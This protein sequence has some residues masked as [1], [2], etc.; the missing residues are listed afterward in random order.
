MQD[1]LR[2]FVE[3]KWDNPEYSLWLSVDHQPWQLLEQAGGAPPGNDSLEKPEQKDKP[4]WHRRG[5]VMSIY[6]PYPEQAT[7][8]LCMHLQLEP[9]EQ[10]LFRLSSLLYPYA[11]AAIVEK[12]NNQLNKMMDSIR[13]VTQSVDLD[14]L[15]NKILKNALSVIPYVSVGVLWMFDEQ[16][17]RLRVRARAGEMG[18]GML[19]MRLKPDEGMI[20][21]TFLRGKP[22]LYLSMDEVM[23]DF[24]NMSAENTR[25]LDESYD[26]VNMMSC[27]TVPI[28]IDGQ[29]ECVLI[30]YQNGSEPLLTEH[31]MRLLQSF[32]DQVSIAIRNARLI[33]DLRRQNEVLQRRD[34]IH[35][36][37]IK[38]SLDNKGALPIVSELGRMMS[39]PITYVDLLDAQWHPKRKR[40]ALGFNEQ[41]LRQ[42]YTDVKGPV[43][44]TLPG[45]EPM[46]LYL[47]PIVAV[48]TC[49]GYL[50]AELG[51]EPLSNLQQ[52]AIEQ[53]GAVLALELLRKQSV[54]DIY[55]KQTQDL[56]NELLLAKEPE[57]VRKKADML[58]IRPDIPLM[59]CLAEYA[60]GADIYDMHLQILRLAAD[61]KEQLS[62]PAGLAAFLFAS[63][64][65]VTIG[66]QAREGAQEGTL[67][68]LR[69]LLK[70]WNKQTSDARIRVGTGTFRQGPD[71]VAGSYEEADRAL[72][73]LSAR[74]ETGVMSY[75][76][77]GVNRLFLRQSKEEL[78]AFVSEVFG[79]LQPLGGQVNGLEETL[80]VYIASDRSAQK[81]A[82]KLHIHINTLYQRVRRIEEATGLS[83]DDQEHRLKLQLACYLRQSIGSL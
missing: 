28:R 70:E 17:G 23:E 7:I 61:L 12:H 8:A 67:A 36:T 71:A 75:P 33:E 55:Y 20:G 62:R 16:S 53:G 32:A 57:L 39:L 82:E 66:I 78:T 72:S 3:S 56:F 26:F 29:P 83:F 22:R 5:E 30:V 63:G 45:A 31:D 41:E 46:L 44:R 4:Y 27:I 48:Q 51:E 40:R 42:L 54:A 77:I 2:M 58:G 47:Y 19:K 15:L 80:L 64:N 79:P 49:L 50:I 60:P 68:K 6:L 69:G 65:K 35:A 38:L 9:D 34:H 21:K 24:G 11:A 10:D 74:N 43:F 59:I 81:S 76:E 25:Y 37:F 73:Y 14:E 1:Q 52:I 13:D 18:E